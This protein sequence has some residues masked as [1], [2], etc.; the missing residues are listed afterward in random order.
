MMQKSHDAQ[1]FETIPDLMLQY[2]DNLYWSFKTSSSPEQFCLDSSPSEVHVS[3]L[4]AILTDKHE[5]SSIGFGDPETW[6][7]VIYKAFLLDMTWLPHT[8]KNRP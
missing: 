3:G 1:V 8:G 7:S 6:N 5:T 4:W 2:S